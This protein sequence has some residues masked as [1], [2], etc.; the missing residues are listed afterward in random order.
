MQPE[1][2]PAGGPEP[3]GYDLMSFDLAEGEHRRLAAVLAASPDVDPGVLMAEES[4]AHR[5]LYDGLDEQQRT[6]Y[7]MLVEAGVLDA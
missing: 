4:Q 6:T 3:D 2:R 5:M 7:R 1:R